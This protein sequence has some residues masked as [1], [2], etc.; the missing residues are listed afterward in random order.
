MVVGIALSISMLLIG[1]VAWITI[2]RREAGDDALE[3]KLKADDERARSGRQ[4]EAD[5]Q[6]HRTRGK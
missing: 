1:Y 2:Q 5:A 6:Q 3:E 4:A